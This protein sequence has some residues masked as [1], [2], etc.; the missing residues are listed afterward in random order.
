VSNLRSSGECRLN[1]TFIGEQRLARGC[2]T[3]ED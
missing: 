1:E 3:P 2:V